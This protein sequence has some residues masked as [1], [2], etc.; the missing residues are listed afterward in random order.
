MDLAMDTMVRVQ[1]LVEELTKSTAGDEHLA[2]APLA[3]LKRRVRHDETALR[4]ALHTL[5]DRLALPHS[6]VLPPREIEREVSHARERYLT[7][8]DCLPTAHSSSSS[9]PPPFPAY[10]LPPS[11]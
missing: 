6:Q 3:E 4:R 11:C 7:L 1:E 9:S 5:M 10:T 2:S 8:R